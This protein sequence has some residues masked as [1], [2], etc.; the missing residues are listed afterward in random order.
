M[1]YIKWKNQPACEVIG[2]YGGK[3]TKFLGKALS[4]GVK[5]LCLDD[6]TRVPMDNCLVYS[7][8]INNEWSFDETMERY[9]CHVIIPLL[10]YYF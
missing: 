3:I 5:A 10:Y 8:G 9:G 2:Y 6:G 4:E 7:V 1:N